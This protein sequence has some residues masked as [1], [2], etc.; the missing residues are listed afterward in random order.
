MRR[1]GARRGDAD[2]G[3]EEVGRADGHDINV[4]V[5][6]HFVVIEGTF[7]EPENIARVVDSRRLGVGGNDESGSDS[8]F[9][10]HNG[11][12]LIGA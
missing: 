10:I 5:S 8:Q 7:L 6:E 9:G 3:V 4:G 2:F 12:C 1:A 11:D